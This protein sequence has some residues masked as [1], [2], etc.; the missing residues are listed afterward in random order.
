MEQAARVLNLHGVTMEAIP[1]PDEFND[2]DTLQRLH[3]IIMKSDAHVSFLKEYLHDASRLD[4]AI[5]TM[6]EEGARISR[7]DIVYALDT[8]AR[9]RTRF[10][11]LAGRYIVI[12]TPSA[13]DEAAEGLSD[14]GSAV[15][16]WVWTVRRE[17]LACRFK[18]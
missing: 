11:E 3:G 5:R 18:G 4:A 2:W 8:F 1:F 17:I 13:I 16:N 10:H 15:F 6:I 7:A 9:M 12:L 14:M